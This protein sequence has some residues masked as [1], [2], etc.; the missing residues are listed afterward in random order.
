MINSWRIIKKTFV[1]VW[2]L[3][4]FAQ[5]RKG[6]NG[7]LSVTWLLAVMVKTAIPGGKLSALNV[8]T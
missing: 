7:L 5:F 2:S 1:V 3:L 6:R 8:G 4:G